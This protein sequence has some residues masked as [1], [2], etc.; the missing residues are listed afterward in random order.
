MLYVEKI[1]TET[2]AKSSA[3]STSLLCLL[4]VSNQKGK[5]GHTLKK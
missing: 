4:C 1:T 2:E 5:M 3:L